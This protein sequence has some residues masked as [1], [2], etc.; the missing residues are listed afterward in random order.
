M[1]VS[2]SPLFG[3]FFLVSLSFCFSLPSSF[4]PC[5]LLLLWLHSVDSTQTKENKEGNINKEGNDEKKRKK[6]GKHKWKIKKGRIRVF[7]CFCVCFVSACSSGKVVP[8]MPPN[9]GKTFFVC[10]S[11]FLSFLFLVLAGVVVLPQQQ[12][13][14]PQPQNSKKKKNTKHAEE[15]KTKVKQ[16]QQQ[17]WVRLLWGR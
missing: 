13:P 3:C 17:I 12:Q 4:L 9:S 1:F 8:Q 15:N 6:R 16:Q 2:F 7:F 10:L 14:K 11:F 5:F